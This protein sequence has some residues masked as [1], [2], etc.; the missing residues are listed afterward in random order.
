MTGEARQAYRRGWL[1]PGRGKRLLLPLLLFLLTA[2]LSFQQLRAEVVD[3]VVA[4]VNDS[5]ITLSELE[6]AVTAVERQRRAGGESAP[7]RERLLDQLIEG[8]LVEQAAARVGITVSEQEID[9]AVEDVRRR[10][11]ISLDELKKALTGSGITYREYREKLESEIK[12][13]KFS[14]RQFRSKAAIPEEDIASYYR[15]H[16]EKFHGPASYHLGMISIYEP[17]REAAKKAADA[18]LARL[19]KGERFEDVAHR[20][21]DG[22]NIAEGGDLGILNAGELDQ[23][24]ESVVRKLS[25]GAFSDVIWTSAGPAIIRLIDKKGGGV[26]PLAEVSEEIHAILF[27]EIVDGR[28][29]EWLERMKESSHIDIRL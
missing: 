12:Q 15:Q 5:V 16:R 21:S 26:R 10:N 28:Y 8:I 29:A 24:I 17:E 2:L 13:V 1:T 4:V 27:Q 23:S 7:P 19:Q 25:V 11:N 22:P 6:R 9:A 14:S 18:I 20:Y 3:R